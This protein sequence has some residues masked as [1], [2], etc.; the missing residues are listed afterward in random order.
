M[1]PSPVT[2]GAVLGHRAPEEPDATA[3]TTVHLRASDRA[4]V[5][6]LGWLD[7]TL[8]ERRDW[9]PASRIARLPESHYSRRMKTLTVR[10]PEGLVAEIEA[11]SR[12]RRPSKSDV[13]RER[14][15]LARSGR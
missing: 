11:E 15:S 6:P 10:L 4:V 1:G 5:T 13:V 3:T 2:Y 8:I 7:E 12:G 14:L 9:P